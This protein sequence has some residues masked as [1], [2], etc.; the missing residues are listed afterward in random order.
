MKTKAIPTIILVVLCLVFLGFVSW[1]SQQLPERVATHFG[2]QGR[3]NG[4]MPKHAAV[5]MMGGFGLGLPLL[6]VAL[7]FLIRFVPPELVN[8]PHREYWLA[9][10]RRHETY[11]FISRQLL[12]LSCMLVCFMA[13]MNWV[14]VEA[15]NSTPVRMP[16]QQFLLILGTFLVAV[17][18]WIIHFVRRFR[19]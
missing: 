15:N 9:P 8:M 11:A 18:F 17:A 3:P 16:N 7:S 10:E 13:A 1:T 14:T 12:W 5:M 4:W 2:F 6:F 19:R